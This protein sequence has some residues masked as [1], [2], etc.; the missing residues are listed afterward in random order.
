MTHYTL[1]FANVATAGGSIMSL[2]PCRIANVGTAGGSFMSLDPSAWHDCQRR[3]D[4]DHASGC[5]SWMNV[6]DDGFE[7][8]LEEKKEDDE[9]GSDQET[10]DFM[11]LLLEEVR[12][13]GGGE[14]E[15]QES[16]EE[17]EEEGADGPRTTRLMSNDIT[18]DFMDGRLHGV[19]A[20][21]SQGDGWWRGGAAGKQGGRGGRGGGWT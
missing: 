9:E 3:V 2:D 17:E 20:G 1:P 8:W 21:G 12:E 10:E 13:M 4:L 18:E 5:A 6:S 7:G 11:A 16:K 14:E 19:V 15:R